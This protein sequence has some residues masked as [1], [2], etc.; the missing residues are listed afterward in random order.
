MPADAFA[1]TGVG[2]HAAGLAG[3]HF[4]VGLAVS[5]EGAQADGRVDAAGVDQRHGHAHLEAV[6]LVDGP[7]TGKE[8]DEWN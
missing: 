3:V 2:I 6:L 7:G 5:F 4:A 1:G 8:R